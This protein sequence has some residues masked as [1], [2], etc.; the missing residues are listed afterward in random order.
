M[1]NPM[2]SYLTETIR[3]MDNLSCSHPASVNIDVAT[4]YYSLTKM[5]RPLLVV[6]IGCFIGFSTH[7]F[8]QALKE[9]GFGA[10]ISI[11]AFDWE[12]DAGKGMQNRQFIAENYRKKAGLEGIITFIKGYSTEVYAQ[13]SGEIKNKIDLLYI[14]GDHSVGG[15]FADFNTYYNDVRPGG[16][17]ILHDIYPSM[18]GVE[19]PRILID[20]LK[21]SGAIPYHVELIEMQ[22]RD[23]FGIAILRKV[24]SRRVHLTS[25]LPRLWHYIFN[26]FSKKILKRPVGPTA[27]IIKVID[28]QTRDPIAGAT[29]SCPQRGDEYRTTGSDGIVR[30]D[31]YLPNRY[32]ID[33]SATGYENKYAVMIDIQAEKSLQEFVI[34]MTAE[35]ELP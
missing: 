26:R 35:A 2:T 13:I 34:E 17:L 8:A 27:L 32:L 30:L 25:S 11:D 20:Q 22:T 7:H 24:T 16:Y 21:R 23:G 4:I 19:G 12:V 18:C 1:N 29:I 6:E 5:L 14:D 10:I 31:H 3:E 9:L 28:G 33:V 15:V